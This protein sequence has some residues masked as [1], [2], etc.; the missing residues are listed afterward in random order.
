M[1]LDPYTELPH[2]VLLTPVYYGIKP[3]SQAIAQSSDS[4]VRTKEEK[5]NHSL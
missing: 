2:N 5:D 1:F 4:K 3:V